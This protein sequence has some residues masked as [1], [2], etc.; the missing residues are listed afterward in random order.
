MGPSIRGIWSPINVRLRPPSTGMNNDLKALPRPSA[1]LHKRKLRT[2]AA[3]FR[4]DPR[5]FLG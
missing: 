5:E 4:G 1:T 3:V 2:K